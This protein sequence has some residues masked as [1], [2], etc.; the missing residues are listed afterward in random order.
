M[1][2]KKKILTFAIAMALTIS[3]V[4]SINFIGGFKKPNDYFS[5]EAA[6]KEFGTI[7]MNCEYSDEQKTLTVFQTTEYI[8]RTGRNMGEVKFHIYAN[9][10]KEDAAF[11]AVN[12]SEHT[13]A[14]PNGFSEGYI[15]VTSPSVTFSGLDETVLTV[16]LTKTLL[17]NEKVTIELEYLVQLANIKHRLG[18]SDDTVNLGNFYPV[19][20]VYD[21]AWNTYPYSYNGD[22]FYNDP[23]N[24]EVTLNTSN[25]FIVASSGEKINKNTYRS[26]ITR[27]FAFVLSKDFQIKSEQ[28]GGTTVN[29]YYIDDEIP[30]ISMHT[31]RNSLAFFS[32]E[33]YT[34]PYPTLAVV[35]TDFLHGGMEYGSL[36]YISRD[37]TDQL[38]YQTVIVH[39]IA[40][41]W[42]YGIIGNNQTR[43]AWIDEG[44]A[45]YSTA[46]FFETHPQYGRTLTSIAEENTSA[47]NIYESMMKEFEVPYS[48]NMEQDLH[49]FK[50]SFEYTM[51]TYSRGMLL[52]Y[53]IHEMVS[54][55]KLNTAL[56]SYIEENRFDFASKTSLIQH[57]EQELGRDL[58]DYF[59]KYLAGE[60]L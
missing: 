36:V 6:S 15:R 33:F 56:S 50:S 32:N 19:P 18:Y 43:S 60:T 11:P 2:I 1:P 20:V 47:I 42:W 10:Y 26:Y 21:N 58:E 57:L 49:S 16:P 25:D 46:I 17:P 40:H 30:D 55:Q 27:D 12:Q 31:A 35:Q 22:P 8:N 9:A 3:I 54:Y 34:Y 45:E 28:V 29:Y 52:F 37:V 38:Q 13:R 53:G 23:Y 5:L 7:S 24:F 4:F 59:N 48:M 44:L 14:Y 51:N 39:E 41:Q